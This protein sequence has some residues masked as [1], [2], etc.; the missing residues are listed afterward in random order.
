MKL[1]R[2]LIAAAF[3]LFALP[4]LAD[5]YAGV[6]KTVKG[7]V[8][9]ECVAYRTLAGYL[10]LWGEAGC[11]L[12]VDGRLYQE[13]QSENGAGSRRSQPARSRRNAPSWERE[14]QPGHQTRT[15]DGFRG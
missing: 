14:M 7:T 6:V 10:A 15:I 11:W 13:A 8:S 5:D 1:Q 3:G 2:I 12:T 9:V 4:A